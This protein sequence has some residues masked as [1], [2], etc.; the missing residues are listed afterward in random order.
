MLTLQSVGQA[1][2]RIIDYGLNQ[3]KLTSPTLYKGYGVA[4]HQPFTYS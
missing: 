1:T 3:Y 2:A 4:R